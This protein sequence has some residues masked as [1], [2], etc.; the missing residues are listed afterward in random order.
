MSLSDLDARV[1]TGI[2]QCLIGL[3]VLGFTVKVWWTLPINRAFLFGPY[4]TAEGIKVVLRGW[5]LLF[6]LGALALAGGITRF[7][8]WLEG[9]GADLDQLAGLAGLVEA[10]LSLWAAGALVIFTVRTWLAWRQK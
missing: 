4:L 9:L 2:C 1:V 5:P 6:L 10:S 3:I 8:Y 7:V